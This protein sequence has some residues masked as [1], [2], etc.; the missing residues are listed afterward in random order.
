MEPRRLLS[1]GAVLAEGYLSPGT[2]EVAKAQSMMSSAAAQA[3]QKYTADLARVE[4]SSDVTPAEFKNLAYDTQKLI[5]DIGTA[6]AMA[7]DTSGEPESPQQ[8]TQQYIIVQN[9]VDQSFLAG[10]YRKAGWAELQAD[11]S[12]ALSDVSLTTNIAQVTL[13][14][15]EKVARAAHVTLAESQQLAADQQALT[16]A[17]GPHADSELNS[18]DPRDPAVVYYNGQVNLFVHKR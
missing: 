6:S 15:M 1:A 18:S 4:Q 3:T 16:T 10:G 12:N 13:M 14:Q 2:A 8:L 7:S 5:Q 11:L 9:A 17:L